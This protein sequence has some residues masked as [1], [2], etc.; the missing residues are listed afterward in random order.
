MRSAI[1]VVVCAISAA[2]VMVGCHSTRVEVSGKFLG[3][4]AR[5]V[6]LEK[7]LPSG[8]QTLD[9]VML[10]ED[11]FYRFVVEDADATPSMYHVVYNNV[12]IPLLLSR[13]E[14][15]ELGSLGSVMEN[16]TVSGSEESELLRKFNRD[17]IAGKQE[18]QSIMQQYARA[19]EDEQRELNLLYNHTRNTVKRNQISFIIEHKSNVAAVYALYQRL[20]AE[21]YLVGPDS[22]LIYYRTVADALSEV[23]PAS[24]YLVRLNNDIARMEARASLISSIE[25]RTYP[26]LEAP[27]MYGNRVSLS[28]LE[29]NVVL[30]DFW[31]AELGNSNALNADLKEI[32]DKYEERG[33]RVYQVAADV[34]KAVWI[35]AVQEQRLPWVSVCDF[36]GERSPLLGL[37]N[38]RK[39]PSN[40]L[41]DRKGNIIAKDIYSTA[42]DK[43]LAELL[44]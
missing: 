29:G 9:T 42:L 30:V 6:Y 21:N 11:G 14:R 25:T 16:Y 23:Y 19:D 4:N 33:F 35:R 15:V 2:V 26:D 27:D 44:D 8:L 41:I 37:Y 12:R 3:L 20:P 43:R 31:S 34:S 5:N 17:Y 24:P 18:L 22:D 7:I 13:G 32:Y 40:F 36:R 10:A 38:V 39:L 1:F 28:S